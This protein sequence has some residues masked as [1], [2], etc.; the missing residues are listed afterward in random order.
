MISYPFNEYDNIKI[1]NIQD[2]KEGDKVNYQYCFNKI[3][4]FIK[5]AVCI[6]KTKSSVTF[7]IFYNNLNSYYFNFSNIDIYF[8]TLFER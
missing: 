5:E 2:I 4:C 1:G 7:V 3:N 6:A 8:N